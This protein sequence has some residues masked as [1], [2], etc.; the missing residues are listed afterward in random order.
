MFLKRGFFTVRDIKHPSCNIAPGRLFRRSL[1]S[2]IQ[3][4]NL[5]LLLPSVFV[6]INANTSRQVG[7]INAVNVKLMGDSVGW[8]GPPVVADAQ[9]WAA[10]AP[11]HAQPLANGYGTTSSDARNWH[12]SAKGDSYLETY[13]SDH[14]GKNYGS[15]KNHGK[16]AKSG[17]AKEN[18]GNHTTDHKGKQGNRSRGKPGNIRSLF[19]NAAPSGARSRGGRRQEL[20][21]VDVDGT[22]ANITKRIEFA[23]THG[24]KGSSAYWE[25]LLDGEYYH[26]D[27]P[28]VWCRTFL[29]AWSGMTPFDEHKDAILSSSA[30][31]GNSHAPAPVAMDV[32]SGNASS[33]S[34]SGTGDLA[35]VQVPPPPQASSSGSA[36]AVIYV[37]GRRMGTEEQTRDWLR[38]HGFPDGEIRHRPRGV[39][40]MLWKRDVLAE[41]KQRHKIVAHIGDRDDDTDAAA[42]AGVRGIFVYPDLW[43]TRR[44]AEGRGVS[45][46]ITVFREDGGEA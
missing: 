10:P 39:R 25:A 6:H 3:N 30:K 13:H 35:N 4:K 37:S 2:H 42:Q 11:T 7:N 14:K 5:P 16:S 31:D 19:S 9:F 8:D 12:G 34:S 41:L 40:S 33:S 24:K 36:R 20:L 18:F 23:E 26:L 44:Q 28:I 29:R 15:A 21:S 1:L 43:L 38:Q 46:L 27:E 22:V 17:R 32:D 45:D